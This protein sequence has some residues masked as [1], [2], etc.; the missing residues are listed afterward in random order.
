MASQS[1]HPVRSL[2]ALLLV[3]AL[4]AGCSRNPMPEEE[5]YVENAAEAPM[6]A[7]AAPGGEYAR[8]AVYDDA[9]MDI[10][11]EYEE[12][13]T[14]A[15]EAGTAD[16]GASAG[17]GA[18]QNASTANRKIIITVDL[19]LETTEFDLGTE[20]IEAIAESLGGYVQDS[21]VEGANMHEKYHNRSANYTVRVPTGQLGDFLDQMGAQYNVLY[22]QRSTN[23]ISAQYFDTEA[24]LQSLRI[25]EERLIALLKESADLEYLLQVER[26]LANVLY[27][28]ESITSSLK[29]MDDS[30]DL[31]TITIRLQ[32]VSAYDDTQVRPAPL[33]FR[34]R[35]SATLKDS[36]TAFLN[37][38]QNLLLICV[39]LLPFLPLFAVIGLL[40]WLVV[41]IRRKR[42]AKQQPLPP[43]ATTVG[44]A[45]PQ[46]AAPPQ[47]TDA[48]NDEP[49]NAPNDPDRPETPTDPEQNQQG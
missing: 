10:M 21:Y 2:L 33:T 27:Q 29:R 20:Q 12:M 1:K 28:I 3:G 6:T 49:N 34:E 23:D 26:E 8:D 47:P 39:A 46:A 17:A 16:T 40:I 37:F 18:V 4:L 31:A 42:R 13:E 15:Q 7:P 48:P 43:H 9:E 32:E 11:D 36:W 22:R 41:R 19:G 30:V 14:A 35:A 25:Q 24:R 38:C 5:L 45:P 44:Y